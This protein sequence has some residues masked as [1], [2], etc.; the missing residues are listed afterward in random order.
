[1]IVMNLLLEWINYIVNSLNTR[2]IAIT[3]LVIVFLIIIFITKKTRKAILKLFKSVFCTKLIFPFIGMILYISL[4]SY[5][6]SQIGLL[7][8]S[9]IKDVIIWFIIGAIPLFYKTNQINKK[10]K[11]FFRNN[12]FEFISITTIISFIYNFYTFNIIIELILAIIVLFL[13]L[14]IVVSKTNEEYKN[15]EKLFN[16]FLKLIFL[17]LF[18]IFIHYLLINPNGFI[19][20]NTVI[21]Y[22]LPAILTISLLPYI[23]VFALYMEYKD[24]YSRLKSLINDSNLYNQVFRK[25]LKKYKLD[26]FGLTA[27]LSEFKIFNIHDKKNVE[28][29][30][31]KAEKRVI[32]KN[33]TELTKIPNLSLSLFY[34]AFNIFENNFVNFNKQAYLK[35]E[36]NSTDTTLNVMFYDDDELIGQIFSSTTIDRNIEGMRAVSKET[37]II[38]EQN[39]VEDSDELSIWSYIFIDDND[40]GEKMFISID[41]DLLYQTTYNIIKNTLIIIQ[42]P[43]D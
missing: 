27:F 11:N 37:T 3:I 16:I 5:L 21:I 40:R 6:L 22:I 9:L 4:I 23:Y 39:A 41:F 17:G 32:K 18:I 33:S 38:A 25:V 8:L 20:I 28:K 13:T 35:I 42:N 14:L 26:Y 29:E 1:M 43:S 19:N 2:E 24:F 30:I 31:L 36:D 12:I 15:V 34:S 10:Y 7:N